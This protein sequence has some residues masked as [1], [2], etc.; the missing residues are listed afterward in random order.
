M[1]LLK[2][3]SEAIIFYSFFFLFYSFFYFYFFF[4]FSPT[5]SLI[6]SSG[7][8]KE[9]YDTK[10]RA[11]EIAAFVEDCS[12]NTYANFLNFSH[13]LIQQLQIPPKTCSFNAGVYVAD[14]QKWKHQN[15]AVQL[16]YWMSTNVVESIYGGGVGGGGSQPPMLIA[17][18]KKRANL[19]PLWHVRHLGWA[20][21]QEYDE[22]YIKMAKLLHWNG[23]NKP[24][25]KD[26]F[27]FF[28]SYWTRYCVPEPVIHSENHNNNN[29]E[30]GI[31]NNDEAV[32]STSVSVAVQS[33]SDLNELYTLSDENLN[34]FEKDYIATVQAQQITSNINLYC[35]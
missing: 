25:L 27:P 33:L 15:I 18:Y 16:N 10:L 5:P 26:A 28:R 11:N 13:P 12:R 31:S 32:T 17:F 30:R 35:Q 19:D 34:S 1:L 23:S 2:V 20:G 9:F 22:G 4:N 6:Q 21:G 8:V 3:S 24:W 29:N 14:L 7:D